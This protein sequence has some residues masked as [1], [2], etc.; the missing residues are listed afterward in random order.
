MSSLPHQRL[1]TTHKISVYQ[2]DQPS[3]IPR[4]ILYIPPS[5]AISTHGNASVA[6]RGLSI[7][8]ADVVA[9]TLCETAEA[10]VVCINYRS[11]QTAALDSSLTPSSAIGSRID[12]SQVHYAWPTPIHDVTTA[13]DWILSNLVVKEKTTKIGI[14]G[15][16]DGGSLA[17]SLAMTECHTDAQVLVSAIATHDAVVDWVSIPDA[18]PG[19]ALSHVKAASF[20][21]PATNP[22][23][24]F[25]PFASP[26][27]FLRTPRRTVPL[28]AA[29]QAAK[30]AERL[31]EA[32]RDVETL[33]D[34]IAQESWLEDGSDGTAV[35]GSPM[36]EHVV[37]DAVD[38]LID[39]FTALQTLDD[40][41]TILHGIDGQDDTELDE[42]DERRAKE[43]YAQVMHNMAIADAS[44]KLQPRATE[45]LVPTANGTDPKNQAR[46]PKRASSK[47]KDRGY[48]D[49]TVMRHR[50]W[51][52]SYPLLDIPNFRLSIS[53]SVAAGNHSLDM[54]ILATQN[55]EMASLLRR[56]V[57][58][59]KLSGV[60]EDM[61]EYRKKVNKAI[62]GTNNPDAKVEIASEEV[63]RVQKHANQQVQLVCDSKTTND[64]LQDVGHWFREYL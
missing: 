29:Q 24:P 54:D 23:A 27:H 55:K 7:P 30:D 1:L 37:E 15:A 33:D 46:S 18:T 35:I 49:G 26:I 2:A 13:F 31:G 28:T 21:P 38:E 44:R 22:G 43:D 25:D 20:P 59:D 62:D 11:S 64:Q 3:S 41:E 60:K 19:N 61:P 32:F 14:Y 57:A 36:Q 58:R 39:D 10:T 45:S 17:L 47:S 50:K 40:D 12:S 8:A 52:P 42:W 53:E 4:F 34:L 16:L 6:K 51:P 56:A 5:R 63:E 48:G 9:S